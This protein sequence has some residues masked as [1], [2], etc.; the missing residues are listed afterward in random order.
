MRTFTKP[1][2]LVGAVAVLALGAPVVAHAASDE[3][4]GANNDLVTQVENGNK[5]E[6]QVGQ[7]GT[8][9]KEGPNNDLATQVETGNKDEGQVGD[10]ATGDGSH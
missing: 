1:L 10:G 8:D 9:E 3:P 5:D 2:T 6:G 4:E 7:N